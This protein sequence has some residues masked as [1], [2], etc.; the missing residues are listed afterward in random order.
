M[1]IK[2]FFFLTF[3]GG[4]INVLVFLPFFLN[5]GWTMGFTQGFLIGRG[6]YFF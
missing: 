6:D 3:F 2:Y 4:R 5:V 1:S